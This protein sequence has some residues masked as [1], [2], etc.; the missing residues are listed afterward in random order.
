M[1]R[2]G[3]WHCEQLAKQAQA[4]DA[5][6]TWHLRGFNRA[7][8][9]VRQYLCVAAA[10]ARPSE[11]VVEELFEDDRFLMHSDRYWN[12]TV[13]ELTYLLDAPWSLWT[14]IASRLDV[15]PGEYRRWVLDCSVT[16]I[17]FLWLD[18]WRPLEYGP[19]SFAVGDSAA[20]I[21]ALKAAKPRVDYT[22]SKMQVLAQLGF[23]EEVI[24]GP[25]LL[26]EFAMTTTLV[27]QARGSGSQLMRRHPTFMRRHPTCVR[28]TVHN[29]RSAL[30][31]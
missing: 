1:T 17:G 10:C 26:K 19:M 3:L 9:E 5:V 18:M 20:K 25:N 21:E 29:S 6:M 31:E 8:R 7:T 12:S 24:A 4:S 11:A 14:A 13:D 15:E 30:L 27:E 22:T 2:E 23:D 16:S 28:A